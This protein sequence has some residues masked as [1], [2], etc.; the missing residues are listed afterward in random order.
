MQTCAF[1]HPQPVFRTCYSGSISADCSCSIDWQ[2]QA[3]VSIGLDVQRVA[4]KKPVV[5]AHAPEGSD[6][7]RPKTASQVAQEEPTYRRHVGVRDGQVWL[8]LR[9]CQRVCVLVSILSAVA[10]SKVMA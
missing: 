5:I 3:C 8:L 10:D 6:L 4:N 9:F 2:Q 1:M 7:D